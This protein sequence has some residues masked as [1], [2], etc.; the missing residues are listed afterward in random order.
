MHI[1]YLYNLVMVNAEMILSS[2]VGFNTCLIAN[3]PFLSVVSS[4]KWTPNSTEK[5]E[6]V[7]SLCMKRLFQKQTQPSPKY[8]CMKQSVRRALTKVHE[9]IAI[10]IHEITVILVNFGFLV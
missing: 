5:E 3:A 1:K 9:V 4:A 8:I 7:Q 2:N 6:T 10:H